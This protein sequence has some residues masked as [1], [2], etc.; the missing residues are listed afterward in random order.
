MAGMPKVLLL[1]LKG[2]GATSFYTMSFSK[3]GVMYCEYGFQYHPIY[4][5]NKFIWELAS[6]CFQKR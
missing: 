6:G 3:D 1:R 4:K 2:D 5:Y